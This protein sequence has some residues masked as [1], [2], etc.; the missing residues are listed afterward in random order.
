MFRCFTVSPVS[1]KKCQ[2]KSEKG[3]CLKH[4]KHMK[5]MKQCNIGEIQFLCGAE[6]VD[7]IY[8]YNNIL[9]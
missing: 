1:V 6:K 3:K 5:H 7:Y 8:Y 9:G 4:M 2:A